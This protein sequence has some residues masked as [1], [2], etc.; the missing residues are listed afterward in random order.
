MRKAF[1]LFVKS[2]VQKSMN[3][4]R[5]IERFKEYIADSITVNKKQKFNQYTAVCDIIEYSRDLMNKYPGISES[6]AIS[7]VINGKIPE[8]FKNKKAEQKSYFEYCL[9]EFLTHI[10]DEDIKTAV[11]M[12]I[13]ES[14]KSDNLLYIYNNVNEEYAPRIRVLVN[15]F[16]YYMYPNGKSKYQRI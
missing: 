1:L 14:Q 16:W 11:K 8:S 13:E 4:L 12:S 9:K 5:E 2:K 15:M 10:D 7:W 3:P 6:E